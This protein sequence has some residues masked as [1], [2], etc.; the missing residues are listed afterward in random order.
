MYY[1]TS[2]THPFC[3]RC[4]PGK[5]ANN[6]LPLTLSSRTI[7]TSIPRPHCAVILFQALPQSS[8]GLLESCLRYIYLGCTVRTCCAGHKS[9][10]IPTT[11]QRNIQHQSTII[12]IIPLSYDKAFFVHQNNAMTGSGYY[13]SSRSSS[14]E[15]E[16]VHYNPRRDQR[17]RKET[18]PTTK[19]TV[20]VVHHDRP[21][22]DTKRTSDMVGTKWK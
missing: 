9:V 21:T 17:D 18:R 22:Y 14:S 2:Y 1:K 19:R 5:T 4:F 11:D 15:A 20:V 8:S 13:E 12:F 7:S 3:R 6:T 16:R 10:P